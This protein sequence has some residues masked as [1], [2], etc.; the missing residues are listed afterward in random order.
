MP[1]DDNDDDDDDDD[2]DGEDNE[3]RLVRELRSGL[4]WSDATSSDG[5]AGA[6]AVSVVASV[7][8]RSASSCLDMR[9]VVC[10]SSFW[11]FG[12]S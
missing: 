9:L 1:G 7:I 12:D 6:T 3:A 2:D 4:A 10:D 8:P 11:A 5:T